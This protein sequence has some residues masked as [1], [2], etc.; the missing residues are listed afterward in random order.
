MDTERICPSCKKPL[1][2]EV[3]LGLCPE[4]LVKAGFNT[5]TEPGTKNVGFVPPAVEELTKLFPQLEILAFIGSGGMG[6]VYKARQPALDRLVALKILPSGVAKDPGFT[7]R[8][9]H[10]ARALAKLTHPNIVAVHDFGEAG[11]LNYLIMEFVDG[12]NLRQVERAARL[13]P[14]QA[15]AIVPQI[16]EALQFAHN[17]GIV[18]RDIKPENILVDKTGRVKITDF[19]I[20]KILGQTSEKTSLTGAGD[21]LGTPHYM[22]PEQVEHPGLVDHRADIFSLGVVFYEMLT[23]ELPLGK[24]AP[25]SKK[26]QVDVRLDEVVLHALEKEPSR[27][28]QQA[29]QVKTDVETVSGTPRPVAAPP[30]VSYAQTAAPAVASYAGNPSSASAKITAPAVALMVV[31]AWKLLSSFI[32]MLFLPVASGHFPGL[33]H[34]S[35]EA[36]AVAN[37]MIGWVPLFIFS[38]LLLKVIPGLLILFGGYQML[39]RRS[40]AWSIAAAIISIMACSLIGFPIGIWA[41]I[42]L[43]NDD[44]KAAFGSNAPVMAIAPQ[45][46][47]P[48]GGFTATKTC[49][50]LALVALGIVFSLAGMHAWGA[51]QDGAKDVTAEAPEQPGVHQTADGEFRKDFSQSFPF[52]ADG[53]L[54]LEHVKGRIIIHGW[55]TNLVV[56]NAVIHGKT[57]E[58]AEAVKINIDSAPD[59]ALI[60]TEQPSSVTGFPWS[61]LWFKNARRNDASVDYTLQV[62]RGARLEDISSVNGRTAIDGVSGDITANTVNGETTVKGAGRNLKLATVNGRLT[63]DM[64][65]LGGG[66]TVSLE[67]VNGHVDLALPED[68]NANV[69]VNTINGRISSEFPSLEAKKEFPVGNNLRGSLGDGSA[70]VRITAVNGSIKILKSPTAGQTTASPPA[71]AQKHKHHKDEAAGSGVD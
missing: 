53:R 31:A 34:F 15:L 2:S 1:P 20:A 3:P 49:V 61:W 28:Y 64:A 32:P 4:C 60:H 10:E 44:V 9:N 43:A 5:G 46:A 51:R 59:K 62:P 35:G 65:S 8:F 29:S 7:E 21:V 54:S 6:A 42:V 23:G 39:Q 16:C 47:R 67:T 25:P 33:G 66:Q 50:L 22:A 26:V 70:T 11:G 14:E 36:A 56:V 38:I 48:S 58:S 18:H 40:Y 12:G 24:F 71:V 69:S 55:S 57:R 19:G 30:V 68:A 17:A 45:L 37:A 27:R 63:A 52:N 13:T 41:L